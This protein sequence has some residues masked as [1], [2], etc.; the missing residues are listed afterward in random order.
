[1][2]LRGQQ[3]T[4]AQLVT[5][6]GVMIDDASDVRWSSTQK[7][8]ALQMAILSARFSWLEE[9][10]DDTNTYS[11]NTYRYT[12]PPAC[13]KVIALYFE[14]T[15][16]TE[17]RHEINSTVW[18]IENDKIVFTYAYDDYDGQTMY[19]VYS[20]LP[21]NLLTIS[22]TDGAVASAT[23]AAITSATATFITD[24]VLIGDTVIINESGYAGNGTYYIESVDSETQ[25][26]LHDVPGTIGTS[27]DFTVSQ[28]TDMP[29]DYLMHSSMG[30][31]YE[32]A[33][34]NAPGKEIEN[35]IKMA[36]YYRQLAARD[37]EKIAR[38]PNPN[39]SY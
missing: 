6:L 25:L 1:M 34:R 33:M 7:E 38:R 15:D 37:L 20:V 8:L 32:I 9:R 31:L 36:V 29:V 18:H 17:P 21:G 5:K 28:Y 26:T 13:Y 11:I 19:I 39:R 16:S 30:E 3:W 35:N 22:L 23:T 24:E 10:L 4:L 14:P 2:T 12:I 27:L